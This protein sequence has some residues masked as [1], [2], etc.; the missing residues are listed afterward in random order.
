MVAFDCTSTIMKC[1]DS[2]WG[3]PGGQLEEGED[4]MGMFDWP[5]RLDS[6]DGEQSVTLDAMVDT[7]SSYTIV[8]T[9]LLNELGVE[10]TEKIGLVLADGRTV[11]CDIGQA[12]A[13]IDGRSIPTL[14]VFGEDGA[15][16]LIGAYTL[17]GLRLAVDPA[18][19]TLVPSTAARAP[20]ARA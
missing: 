5:I 4:S 14:V 13:T 6:M 10:P 2:L 16:P 9:R 19:L 7:G 17:E 3:S 1:N 12:L 8:P 15:A 11:T 20:H 18:N